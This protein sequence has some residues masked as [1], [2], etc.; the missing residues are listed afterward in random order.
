MTMLGKAQESVHHVGMQGNRVL[1]SL[2]ELVVGWL[3]VR[4]AAVALRQRDGASEADALFYDGKVASARWFAREVLPNI[5]HAR[6][7][8]ERSSVDVMSFDDRSF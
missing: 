6:A 3:L 2:A 4:H 1:L 7:M 5:A 8:V